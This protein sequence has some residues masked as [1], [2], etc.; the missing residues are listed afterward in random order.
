MGAVISDCGLY[1][2]QLLRDVGEDK[3]CLTF[4][5]LNPS[6]AD[7]ETDDA[8]IRKCIKFCKRMGY[9]KL[10]VLN[11]FALR[12]TDP[13]A[14]KKAR[15][16]VGDKNW[17]IVRT[18]VRLSDYVICAWGTHGTFGRQNEKMIEALKH[19]DLYCL[20]LTKDG[21][22]KHPLYIRDDAEPIIFKKGLHP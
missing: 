7:A 5:M 18:L 19:H 15:D 11:L 20:A 8:T 10:Q 21:H 3:R 14:L 12:A 13:A 22:P 9:G 17:E 16:P 4:I 6:T 1:R 2:Y